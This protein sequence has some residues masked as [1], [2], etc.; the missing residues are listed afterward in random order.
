MAMAYPV[1]SV[2]P[3]DA[4]VFTPAT[5]PSSLRRAPPESPETISASTLIEPFNDSVSMVASDV[6]VTLASVA[7]TAPSAACNSPVPPEFPTAVH[8]RRLQP[9]PRP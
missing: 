9:R 5:S 6:V 7:V 4:A 8:H 2:P 1:M 3:R